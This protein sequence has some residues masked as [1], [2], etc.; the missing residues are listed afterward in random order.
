MNVF[1]DSIH[2]FKHRSCFIKQT[3][4]LCELPLLPKLQCIFTLFQ[5]LSNGRPLIIWRVSTYPAQTCKLPLLSNEYPPILHQ[6][7]SFFY[8]LTGIHLSRTNMQAS[9]INLRVSD[10][11]AQTC[12]LPLSWRLSPYPAQMC[13]LPFLCNGYPISHSHVQASVNK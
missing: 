2:S 13:K 10:H 7:A 8:Y 12:K 3:P 9:F 6:R 4:N 5:P 1:I 11:P